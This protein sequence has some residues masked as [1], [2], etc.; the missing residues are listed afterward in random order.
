MG[1]NEKR[2]LEGLG[3]ALA[4]LS[5][6]GL[7]G[8]GPL[9]GMMGS[10]TGTGAATGTAAA[11]A[12]GIT[13]AGSTAAGLG[14]AA[15]PSAAASAAPTVG[16]AVANTASPSLGQALAGFGKDAAI[17]G[18]KAGST[19]LIAGGMMNAV[20]PPPKVTAPGQMIPMQQGQDPRAMF[21][22]MNM[23]Q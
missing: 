12:A 20:N 18:L 8:A 5:G 17:G 21:P 16:T 22:Q 7:V 9:A 13:G 6:F 3:L 11:N 15:V 10:L 1:H 19:G 14:S 23:F 2:I 4:G